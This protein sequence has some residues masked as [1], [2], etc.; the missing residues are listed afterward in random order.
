MDKGGW[1]LKVKGREVWIE[2]EPD[3][4]Q[5][6]VCCPDLPGCIAFVN[7]LDEAVLRMEAMIE[8]RTPEDR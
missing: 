5:L 1:A 6:I 4:D 3:T 7:S 8:A 2:V